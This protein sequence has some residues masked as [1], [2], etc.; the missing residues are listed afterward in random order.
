[1]AK[2]SQIFSRGKLEIAKRKVRAKI[3]N[4]TRPEIDRRRRSDGE[5]SEKAHQN[6]LLLLFSCH[7]HVKN[8]VENKGVVE[9]QCLP[10]NQNG[11]SIIKACTQKSRD[12]SHGQIRESERGPKFGT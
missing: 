12:K 11:K 6:H 3:E 9:V 5:K 1:M 4:G 10:K 7:F 8:D 2:Q